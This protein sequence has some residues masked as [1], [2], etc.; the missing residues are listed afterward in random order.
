M[1]PFCFSLSLE[2]Q[3]RM[4]L[5]A[6]NYDDDHLKVSSPNS[7]QPNNHKPSPDQVWLP[8]SWDKPPLTQN[9]GPHHPH[10]TNFYDSHMDVSMRKNIFVTLDFLS[11]FMK[12]V[13]NILL[14]HFNF[15]VFTGSVIF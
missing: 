7:E 11:V 3:N 9:R 10:K 1:P 8:P 4:K 15:S 12:L 13:D 6:D 14:K 2:T 5:M